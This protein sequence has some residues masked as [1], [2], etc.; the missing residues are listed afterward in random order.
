MSITEEG[1]ER[2]SELADVEE[3]CE[4]LIAGHD[5]ALTSI[6]SRKCAYLHR[7]C[8]KNML[9]NSSMFGRGILRPRLWQGLYWQLLTIEGGRLILS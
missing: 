4:M 5:I 6:T 7:D 3:M 8:T 1:P 2:M 9:L